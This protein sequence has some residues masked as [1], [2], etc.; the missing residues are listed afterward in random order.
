MKHTLDPFG[1]LLP[2]RQRITRLGSFLRATSID[3][4]PSLLNIV[5]GELSFVGPRPLLVEYLPLYSR[6]QLRRHDVKPGLSGWAQINGRNAISWEEKFILDVWYVDNQCFLLDLRILLLTFLKIL[7]RDG[8][9]AIGEAT[10][11][12]FTGT[13]HTE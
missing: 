9:S 13:V 11:R 3:E 7:R 12:P 4:L 2:D 5:R 8:I 1:R 6:E 10:M